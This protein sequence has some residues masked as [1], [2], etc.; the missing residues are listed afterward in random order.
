MSEESIKLELKGDILI[1]EAGDEKRKYS[2][3]ILLPRLRQGFGGQAA[4]VDFEQRETN[5]K[6]GVLEIKIPKAK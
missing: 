1:L 5:F 3:E 4:K 6:N 2:K